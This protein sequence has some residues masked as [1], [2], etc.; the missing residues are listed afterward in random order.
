MTVTD[1]DRWET[2]WR[3]L[4]ADGDVALWDSAAGHAAVEHLRR[5]R[6]LLDTG[7]PLVDVGC[8]TGGQTVALVGSAPLVV[9]IDF[10]EHALRIA[11]RDN[12]APTVTYRLLNLLDH[13]AVAE[14][15]GELGDANVYMRGLLH[16]LPTSDQDGAM[17]GIA[18][19]LGQRGHLIAQELTNLT[20]WAVLDLLA[21]DGPVERFVRLQRHFGFGSAGGPVEERQL[22]AQ[23]VRGGLDVVASGDDVLRTTQ[24]AADGVP[25]DLPTSWVIARAPRPTPTIE[26]E[27]RDHTVRPH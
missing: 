2:F 25:I 13:A 18:V 10:A 27:P 26:G 9:G 4:A 5:A 16:Q 17:R 1:R 8:G 19:L 21:G 7:L 12:A 11:R 3:E 15:A 23:I 6:P 20:N 14:L 22:D 24:T